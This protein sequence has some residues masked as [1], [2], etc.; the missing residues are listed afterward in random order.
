MTS[1]TGPTPA[2]AKNVRKVKPAA[3]AD[4]F[5]PLVGKDATY[6]PEPADQK[7]LHDWFMSL[8]PEDRAG[9]VGA[10]QK[11]VSKGQKIGYKRVLHYFGAFIKLP[12][13][14]DHPGSL[15]DL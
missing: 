14:A 1:P 4:E 13:M 15:A 12:G 9:A 3:K 10:I 7:E 11:I 2:K 8:S 6:M 5:E